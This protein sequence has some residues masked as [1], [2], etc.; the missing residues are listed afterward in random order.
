[1]KLWRLTD[2][3]GRVRYYENEKSVK[4]QMKK[5][6]WFYEENKQSHPNS[7]L[8]KP[9][10]CEQV[11]NA[12]WISANVLTPDEIDAYIDK[13]RMKEESRLIRKEYQARLAADRRALTGKK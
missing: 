5:V 9:P 6:L 7:P 8:Y 12:E 13:R 10:H 2:Y 1:M 11:V 3:Y 4:T